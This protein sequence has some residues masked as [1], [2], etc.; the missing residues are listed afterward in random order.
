MDF[1]LA[2]QYFPEFYSLSGFLLYSFLGYMIAILLAYY[3]SPREY[4]ID[5]YREAVRKNRKNEKITR[6]F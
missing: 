5:D 2:F 1:E 4:T 3:C 6:P